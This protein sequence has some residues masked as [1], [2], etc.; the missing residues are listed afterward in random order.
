VVQQKPN[1]DDE[2]N[3]IEADNNAT[4]TEATPISEPTVY[5]VTLCGKGQD[6]PKEEYGL[7]LRRATKGHIFNLLAIGFEAGLDI[8]NGNTAAFALDGG[9]ELKNSIFGGMVVH[10]IAYPEDGGPEAAA[11]NRDD[12]S[13]FDEQGWFLGNGNVVLPDGGV[14]DGVACTSATTL[15]LGPNPSLTANAKA[16]PSDG[17]FDTSASYIGAFKDQNDNWA[18]CAQGARA[19]WVVWS[20][21]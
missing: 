12:D 14:P 8:R 21:N 9:L 15:T 5:N 16:P 20:P 11:P 17:F 3:G 18:R 1:F 13:N 4:G 7:L 19:C 10:D 6:N 2:T